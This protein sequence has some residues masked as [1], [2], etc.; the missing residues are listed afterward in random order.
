MATLTTMMMHGDPDMPTPR[1]VSAPACT[2]SPCS[3][4]LHEPPL[5]TTWLINMPRT[6]SPTPILFPGHSPSFGKWF[7]AWCTCNRV[8]GPSSPHAP[9]RPTPHSYMHRVSML[10]LAYPLLICF[11]FFFFL[12]TLSCS[13][14]ITLLLPS[15]PTDA[16]PSSPSRT[17][18]IANTDHNDNNDNFTRCDKRL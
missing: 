11:L 8:A 10:A 17:Y 5:F 16:W 15:L 9:C 3:H 4:P 18:R 6:L 2:V 7:Y 14:V 13:P 12:L 1:L